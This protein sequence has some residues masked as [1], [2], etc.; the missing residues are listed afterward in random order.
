MKISDIQ[1]IRLDIISDELSALHMMLDR[2]GKISRQGHGMLPV[3]PFVVT[4]D[5]DGT[6]FNQLLAKLDEKMFAHA[7][8]YDHPQKK[9]VPVV[10]LVAFLDQDNETEFFEFRFGTE[11]EDLGELLPF[12]DQLI[13]YA[14][15][16]SNHWYE[17]ELKKSK[18]AE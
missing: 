2:D 11:N 8:V 10:M 4:S 14:L 13:S 9:G 16:L 12:F 3:E 18:A 5:S 7:G 6:V 1:R 17:L 15:T